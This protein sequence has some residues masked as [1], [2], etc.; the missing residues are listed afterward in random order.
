MYK[1]LINNYVWFTN[2]LY[3][4]SDIK[5]SETP[6][7]IFSEGHYTKEEVKQIQRQLQDYQLYGINKTINL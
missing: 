5:L 7:G 1:L 4:T 6:N 3:Y 2:S